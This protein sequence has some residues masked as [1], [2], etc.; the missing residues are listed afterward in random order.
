MNSE[1]PKTFGCTGLRFPHHAW[2]AGVLLT[3]LACGG[4]NVTPKNK[5]VTSVPTTSSSGTASQSADA[6]LAEER[7]HQSTRALA[8]AEVA[9]KLAYF[10]VGPAWAPVFDYVSWSDAD[11][12]TWLVKNDVLKHHRSE[13]VYVATLSKRAAELALNEFASSSLEAPESSLPSEWRST[14]T[15]ALLAER[16]WLVCQRKRELLADSC[17]QPL[18]MSE[19]LALTSL[20]SGLSLERVWPEGLPVRTS[21][22]LVGPLEV[23]V[24]SQSKAGATGLAGVPLEL[25]PTA[26]ELGLDT[27]QTSSATF[28]AAVST[29]NFTTSDAQG[30]ARFDLRQAQGPIRIN[31]ASRVLLGPFAG[32]T[33]LPSLEVK[34]RPLEL[35]RHAVVELTQLSKT[36]GSSIGTLL[37][38]ELSLVYGQPQRALN[39]D[40]TRSLRNTTE[41]APAG[42]VAF[43][44][45]Q[46]QRL[47]DTTRGALDYV[48]LVAA[49]SEFASQMGAD[50]TWYQA[51]A[52]AHLVDVWSGQVV[53][54]FDE[55]AT[56]SGFGDHAAEQAALAAAAQKV[57][58][59]LQAWRAE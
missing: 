29:A 49:E 54:Q 6:P 26:N 42:A 35:S 8:L 43:A 33:E 45:E 34:T 16:S 20:L 27:S 59:S 13:G 21:G 17:E 4:S 36:H 40:A 14:L 9:P 10:L 39:P 15:A 2:A 19:R 52:R 3:S 53:A 11:W 46:R 31:V 51:R 30:L 50:R 58:T 47:I 28:G 22:A 38:R 41:L 23:K 12:S 56:G 44:P 24:V 18:P 55:S 57:R 32:L 25:A 37:N 1:F 48:V 7:S 5:P